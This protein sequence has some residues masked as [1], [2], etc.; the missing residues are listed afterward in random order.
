[1]NIHAY[2]ELTSPA[3]AYVSLN[4]RHG[5]VVELTARSRGANNA[6]IVELS[7]EQLRRLANDIYSFLHT[8]Q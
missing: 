2:T 8:D 3:P 5:G 1:M 4:K 7:R 6:S